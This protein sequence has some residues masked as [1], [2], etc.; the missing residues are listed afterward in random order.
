MI[1]VFNVIAKALSDIG[2]GAAFGMM[3]PMLAAGIAFRLQENRVC[4]LVWLLV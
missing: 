1:L 4:A 2:G 3:V